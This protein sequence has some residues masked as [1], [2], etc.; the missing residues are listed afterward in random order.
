MIEKPRE[1]GAHRVEDRRLKPLAIRHADGPSHHE[2]EHER[3]GAL[4]RKALAGFIVGEHALGR[5]CHP[6]FAHHV[7]D[8]EFSFLEGA[9]LARRPDGAVGIR[10]RGAGCHAKQ[11][12][13]RGVSERPLA[14]FGN[15]VGRASD[16]ELIL[17]HP[18]V[19]R[20]HAGLKEVGDNIYIFHLAHRTRRQ[21]TGG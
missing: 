1:R 12:L 21:S 5:S 9:A 20:L 13:H 2:T 3:V 17:N 14:Q 16:C 18:T 11:V 10:V 6:L 19:S 7:G 8:A 15:Q 4:V